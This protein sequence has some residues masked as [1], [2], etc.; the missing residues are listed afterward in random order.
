MSR[1]QREERVLAKAEKQA[2]SA[3]KPQKVGTTGPR[4]KVGKTARAESL[5]TDEQNRV[6]N[7]IALSD[8]QKELNGLNAEIEQLQVQLA[9]CG[10]AALGGTKDPAKEG[11]YGWSP[12]Y[13]DC[14][15]LRLRLEAK[16]NI[17]DDLTDARLVSF[18]AIRVTV[19]LS[20]MVSFP[21]IPTFGAAGPEQDLKI[22]LAISPDWQGFCVLKAGDRIVFEKYKHD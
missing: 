11:D 10:V 20:Q 22:T 7:A 21:V 8:E 19:S 17:G 2:H 13:Q 6:A 5:S 4:P 3:N 16:L 14:L 12:A 9:G 1:K 18:M 15:D